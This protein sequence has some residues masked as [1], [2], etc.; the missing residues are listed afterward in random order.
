MDEFEYDEFVL[1]LVDDGYEVEAGVSFVDDF[2][3]FVVDEV[4]TFGFSGDD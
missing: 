1:I 3:L 2:V 4:A